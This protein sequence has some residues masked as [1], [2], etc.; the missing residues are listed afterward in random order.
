MRAVRAGTLRLGCAFSM[1][2]ANVSNPVEGG[3]GSDEEN[4]MAFFFWIGMPAIFLGILSASVDPV[5]ATERETTNR[6][7][8][9]R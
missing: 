5:R 3:E 9:R 1:A 2:G 7:S 8:Q 4:M 6:N